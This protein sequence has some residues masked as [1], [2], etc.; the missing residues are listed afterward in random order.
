[1]TITAETKI[2]ITQMSEDKKVRI[3]NLY[4]NFYI[5]LTFQQVNG[6]H[7]IDIQERSLV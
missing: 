4:F 6:D 1:M 7:E 5:I 3:F 2:D